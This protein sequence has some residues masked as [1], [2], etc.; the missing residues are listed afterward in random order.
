MSVDSQFSHLAWINTS[1][2]EGGLGKMDIP[3]VSDLNKTISRAYNVLI[4]EGGDA[5]VSLRYGPP[6]SLHGPELFHI[7]VNIC[8]RAVVCS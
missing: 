3:L 7:D 8:L 6:L 2:K 5:G 1:R 4:E